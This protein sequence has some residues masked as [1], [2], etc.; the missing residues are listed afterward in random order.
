MVVNNKVCETIHR[1]DR[2]ENNWK[3]CCWHSRN[4]SSSVPAGADY[5]LAI[6]GGIAM[7]KVWNVFCSAI[8]V[9]LTLAIAFGIG[10]YVGSLPSEESE[11]VEDLSDTKFDL[12]LPAEEEKRIVTAEEVN[13]QLT[14]LAE[15]ATYSGEYT[16]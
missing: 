1:R 12:K 5:R 8:A 4:Y 7:K 16:V 13:L 15:L 6:T 3:S 9:L 11:I 10:Y 14:K 2:Y